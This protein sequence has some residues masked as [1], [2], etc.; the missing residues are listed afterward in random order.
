MDNEKTKQE[1]IDK[2]CEW[3]R[4][5]LKGYLYTNPY[6]TNVNVDEGLLEDFRKELEE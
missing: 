6:S 5:N 4:E 1:I 2:A 3:L